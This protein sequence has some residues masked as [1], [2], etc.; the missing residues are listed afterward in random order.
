MKSKIVI[1][2]RLILGMIF[3]VFGINGFVQ[4]IPMPPPPT[5]GPVG[6]MIAGFAASGYFFPVLKM[7]EIACGFLLVTG[8]FVP[9]AL[10]ILAPVILQIFLFHIFLEPTGTVMAVFLVVAE[11]TLA[12]FYRNAYSSLLTR[13]TSPLI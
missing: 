2:L 4:F 12:Y 13:K 10:V 9:L 7:T 5:E 6:A 3:L 8:Y 11:L 1:G